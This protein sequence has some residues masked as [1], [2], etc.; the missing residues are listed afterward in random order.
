[1]KSL[2]LLLLAMPVFQAAVFKPEPFINSREVA[3]QLYNSLDSEQQAV[4]FRS[5]EDSRRKTWERLPKVREGLKL[6]DLSEEQKN[7]FHR[8]L[9]SALSSEG[10]MMVTA[11]MFNEDIQ[12][13]F[14]PYLGRNEYYI[15][16][17][18]APDEGQ[19]WGWQ[20]E[21]HH[22]SV[23]LTYYGNELISHTPFLLA[24]NPQ[25]VNSDRE[26]NGLCLLY[27][28]EQLA[29][30]L[31]VSLEGEDRKQGYTDRQR[32]AQVYGEIDKTTLKTPDEGVLLKG[33]DAVQNEKAGSLARAYLRYFRYPQGKE[34]AL[35]GEL[36]DKQTRFFF[37][38]HPH[39]NEEHY[40]RIQNERHLIECEN[41]GNH[42]HHFLRSVNDF[43]QAAIR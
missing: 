36:T 30:E 9:Q 21:G 3:M 4:Y 7:L 27:L 29:G 24:S 23:N 40:Y 41:Y 31:A 38:Q 28:E 1:M 17:F 18:G 42:S 37:M 5:F 14:E 25:I 20:L 26:R 8:F 35:I 11:V 33:L 13:R 15:E 22:L 39:Y 10:Y 19:Y 43:G 32:P 34:D 6:A 12:Q 2:F 16:L